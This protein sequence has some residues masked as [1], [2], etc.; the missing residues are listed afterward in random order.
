MDSKLITNHSSLTTISSWLRENTEK[1]QKADIA[2]ARLDCLLLLE[3]VLEKPRDWLLAHDDTELSP[4]QLES[5]NK[6][7]AQRKSHIPLAYIIGSKEFYGRDFFVNEDVLIPR[8]ESEAII[9]ILKQIAKNQNINTIVDVGTGSGCLAVTAK[10]ELGDVH[11]TALE[12][13]KAALKIARKNA[14][15]YGVGIRFIPSDLLSSFPG[16]PKTRPYVIIANLPYVP[17][18]LITSEEITKEPPEALFSGADGLNHYRRFW[19][20]ISNL[21]HLKPGHVITESLKDQHSSMLKLAKSADY[22]L[23]TTKDLIQHFQII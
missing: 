12:S 9:E 20:Q 6:A 21:P 15:R 10:L 16:M 8:P 7:I 11:V 4:N 17:E 18:N 22:T 5:L 13:S 14:R 23:K 2:S 1:L 3:H 19:Q